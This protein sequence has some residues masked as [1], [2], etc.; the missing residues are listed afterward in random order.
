MK[1]DD[2]SK[3]LVRFR[4][5]AATDPFFLG[6]SLS[7][8]AVERSWEDDELARFL[9]CDVDRLPSLMACRSPDPDVP[10]FAADVRTISKFAGCNEDRLLLALREMSVLGVLRSL[11]HVTEHAPPQST[12]LAA[13]QHRKKS[14]KTH[15][16]GQ[17]DDRPRGS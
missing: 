4:R 8:F 10:R 5:R 12:L 13:R 17:D 11:P 16:Q 2:V 7:Q 1:P 14:R 15:E 3:P 9:D 6:Y